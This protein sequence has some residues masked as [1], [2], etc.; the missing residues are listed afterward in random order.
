M[1]FVILEGKNGIKIRGNVFFDGGFGLFYFK[2]EIVDILGLDIECKLLCVVVFGVNLI[3]IDNKIV[4]VC[5]ESI[6]GSVK[7]C[8]FLWIIFKICEMIVVD[9]KL[10]YFCDL[11]IEKLVEYGEV[12]RNFFYY[13]NIV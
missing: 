3:V 11:E 2:E 6:D 1:I 12:M 5:L 13:L 10:D 4:I 9:W 8:V 7:K